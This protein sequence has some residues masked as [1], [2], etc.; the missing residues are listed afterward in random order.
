[1][2][3]LDVQRQGHWLRF[4]VTPKDGPPGTPLELESELTLELP[5]GSDLAVEG[6][7]VEVRIEGL[8]GAI[9]VRTLN[10]PVHLAGKP[11]KVEVQTISGPITT[12][13][14]FECPWTVLRS[15]TGALELGGRFEELTARTADSL[16]RVTATISDEARLESAHGEVRFE[17]ELGPVAKLY[18][19]TMGGEARLLLAREL[20]GH[21]SVSSFQGQ[22]DNALGPAFDREGLRRLSTWQR[23]GR[24]AGRGRDLR[25]QGLPAPR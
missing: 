10:G 1:M 17:G 16:L 7:A 18:V 3:G 11:A 13:A 25:R 19:Q 9:D 14:D 8:A 4:V 2:A 23:H 21:F 5:P 6:P 24:P 22:L 20:E 15:V 12:G